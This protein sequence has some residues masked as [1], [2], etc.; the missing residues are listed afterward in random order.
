[1]FEMVESDGSHR[2]SAVTSIRVL[3]CAAECVR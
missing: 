1:M 3:P 2:L